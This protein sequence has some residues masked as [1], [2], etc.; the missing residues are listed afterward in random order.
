[1]PL[2]GRDLHLGHGYIV[3]ASLALYC[4]RNFIYE[5]GDDVWGKVSCRDSVPEIVKWCDVMRKNTITPLL[6]LTPALRAWVSFGT[7]EYF[8]LRLWHPFLIKMAFHWSW[9]K[10]GVRADLRTVSRSG[11]IV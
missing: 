6:V 9:L 3:M 11:V 4:D 2:R 8:L 7:L 1:M 5:V 10:C